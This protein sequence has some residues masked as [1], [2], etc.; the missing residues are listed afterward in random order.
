[1]LVPVDD[2]KYVGRMALGWHTFWL[3]LGLE[4]M[5]ATQD[6]VNDSKSCMLHYVFSVIHIL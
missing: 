3:V 4:V 2:V 6:V 5:Q 1:M